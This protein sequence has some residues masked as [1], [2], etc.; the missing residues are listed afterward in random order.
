[1]SEGIA[2]ASVP[3]CGGIPIDA[4][5]PMFDRAGMLIPLETLRANFTFSGDTGVAFYLESADLLR[6]I[7]RTYGRDKLRAMWSN[8]GLAKTRTTLGVRLAGLEKR[9]RASVAARAA[10]PW[11]GSAALD[12]IRSALAESSHQCSF[13]MVVVMLPRAGGA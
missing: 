1:M 12:S 9:W 11:P 5:A 13:I 10:P 7:D 6:F 3:N 4:I 2:S 8:G